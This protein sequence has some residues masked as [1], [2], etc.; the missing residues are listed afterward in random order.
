HVW[1]WEGAERSFRRAIELDPNNPEGYHWYTDFLSAMGRREEALATIRRGLELDALSLTMN[2]TLGL[3]FFY[4][5]R[6][7]EAIAQQRRTLELDPTFAPAVRSLGGALEQRGLYDEAIA[8]FQAAAYLTNDLASASLKA[9]TYAVSGQIDKARELLL[10]LGSE[11]R[12]LSPYSVAA[13]HVALRGHD[14]AVGP[15]AG[16]LG[17]PVR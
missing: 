16:G 14:R 7:D 3:T 1:D 2:V 4:A 5:R 13:G 9:H 15:L 10:E 6:Y 12:Y 11:K 17:A 8:A